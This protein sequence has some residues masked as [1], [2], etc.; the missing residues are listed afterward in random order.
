[1]LGLEESVELATGQATFAPSGTWHGF[2]NST[3]GRARMVTV[4]GG[5]SDLAAAGFELP[6][7]DARRDGRHSIRVEALG[8]ALRADTSLHLES[9]FDGLDVY[10]IVTSE[11]CAASLLLLG[12]SS[13]EAEGVHEL[14]RHPNA[15][16]FLLILDGGGYHRTSDGEERLERGEVALIERG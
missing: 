15:E 6:T 7:G 12:R 2:E 1:H 14:H 4:F 11:T 8:H 9:G 10:W 13:F 5:A 16:E 3:G